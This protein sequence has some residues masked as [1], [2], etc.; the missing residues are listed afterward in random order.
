[1]FDDYDDDE[2]DDDFSE[3]EAGEHIHSQIYCVL[4]LISQ[5]FKFS[6]ILF[7][8]YCLKKINTFIFL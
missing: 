4:N 5:F 8:S 7:L 2:D 6:L 1:M 3:D